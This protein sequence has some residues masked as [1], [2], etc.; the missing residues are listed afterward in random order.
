MKRTW[1]RIIAVLEMVGGASGFVFVLWWF[2]AT[3]VDIL[4]AAV[5]LI[6]L[7]IDAFSVI[8]GVALWKGSSFGRIASIVIQAI[9]VP[10]IV[11]HSIIFI[12]SFGFD[13]YFFFTEALGA[14]RMGL[15]IKIGSFNQLVFN[16]V[17]APTG[18]G[19]SISA[20]VF[21]ALL[22]DYK[23]HARAETALPLPPPPPAP[24]DWRSSS[25]EGAER[26]GSGFDEL[27]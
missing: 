9:Q 7:L 1:M 17:G 23:P 27:R 5:G 12:F 20:M 15:E 4:S 19:L 6:V 13:I 11:S 18:F 22:F 21:L 3:P 24:P 25:G 8:A 2:F 10:K 14:V 16:A 26:E